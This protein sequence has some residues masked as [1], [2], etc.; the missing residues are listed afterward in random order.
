MEFYG[1]KEE[2]KGWYKKPRITTTQALCR[3]IVTC[4][5]MVACLT[6]LFQFAQMR[7]DINNLKKT[8]QYLINT[9]KK[10]DKRLTELYGDIYDYAPAIFEDMTIKPEEKE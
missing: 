7:Q 3:L 9:V 6:L 2:P 4:A 1:N 10:Q 5:A 8:N